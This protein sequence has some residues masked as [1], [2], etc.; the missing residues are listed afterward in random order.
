MRKASVPTILLAVSCALWTSGSA[1]VDEADRVV[2]QLQPYQGPHGI[3]AAPEDSM[4][5]FLTFVLTDV[6]EYWVRVFTE[7]DL[8]EPSVSYA[9]PEPGEQVPSSCEA[10]GYSD[11][12]SA[13]Y[14]VVDDQIVISQDFARRI[15][16]GQVRANP[17]P[18]TGNPSGDFSVA[19]V[20]GHEYAHSLQAELGLIRA[21]GTTVYAGWRTE[22]H[23]DC[24]SGIWANSAYQEGQLEPGDV[25]EAVETATLIGDYDYLDPRHHGD[26]QQRVDAFMQGYT[27]GV[28]DSCEF[29]LTE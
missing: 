25:E 14:C 24:W 29:L 15:W 12:N 7:A 13:F 17:D 1:D 3:V 19:Y 4:S 21:N 27:S 10:D 6:D 28:P 8:G 22:L 20:V 26:P 2:S 16:D 9:W 18:A 11:D 5:D 23:A